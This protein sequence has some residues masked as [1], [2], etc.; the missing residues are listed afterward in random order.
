[1]LAVAVG[2]VWMY[3]RREAI[4]CTW[5]D[6]IATCRITTVG[7]FELPRVRTIEGIHALG[8]RNGTHLHVVTDAKNKDETVPFGMRQ[9]DM[10]DDRAADSVVSFLHDRTGT[11]SVGHG[12]AHPGL[13]TAL[14]MLGVLLFGWA[15]RPL[16]FLVTVDPE[17][18]SLLV[19]RRGPLFEA[20][21]SR[22]PLASVRRF[23]VE[24]ARH[25]DRVRLELEGKSLPLTGTFSE[26]EHHGV[27]VERA[28]EILG[29]VRQEGA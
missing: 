25:G 29:A 3:A 5:Q 18:S 13:W 15:T 24:T 12:P 4:D 2:G 22:Y 10:W 19:R 9:I 16:G 7:A 27:F 11:L 6:R 26:G 14:V 21:T 28:A 17:S 20:R 8:H 23:A 1:M